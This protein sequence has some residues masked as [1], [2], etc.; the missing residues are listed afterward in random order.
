[1]KIIL[2]AFGGDNAPDCMI[3]GAIKAIKTFDNIQIVLSGEKDV[4][5]DKLKNYKYDTSKIE[6]LDAEDIITNDDIPTDAIKNKKNS[7]LVRAFDYLK[8]NNEATALISTGSTGAILT[9]TL[10]KIGRIKGVQRPA[11]APF[12][13]TKTGSNVLLLDCGAN[14]DCKPEYLCQFALMGSAYYTCLIGKENPRVALL[15]IGTES[16]KGNAFYKQVYEMLKDLPINFVGNMEARDITS[17]D[18]DIIVADGFDGNIA[19]KATEGGCKLVLGEL[20]S[21]IK[22]SFLAKVGALIMKKSLN[23]L[24][25]KLDYN[26]YGGSI[27]LGAKKIVIKSHGS[28]KGETIFS[29]IKQVRDISKQDIN[30]KITEKL[31]NFKQE[32]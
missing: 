8:E 24:A 10:L 5:F 1:M 7:S 6:I 30:N 13:P 18:Y 21:A 23:K 11:L 25:K 14:V 9:G 28:S 32:E 19:L 15:N 17:G 12:L 26:K 27:F 16:K 31:S 22:S 20:K 4:L 29:A 2:D 3:E